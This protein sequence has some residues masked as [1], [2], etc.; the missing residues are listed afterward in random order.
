MVS[1]VRPLN[2]SHLQSRIL[3][4]WLTSL[5]ILSIEIEVRTKLLFTFM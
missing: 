2:W 4:E 3:P 5:H 1:L